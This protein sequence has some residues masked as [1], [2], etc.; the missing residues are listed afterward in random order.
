MKLA[1]FLDGD[2]EALPP[3]PKMTKAEFARRIGATPQLVIAYI[4]GEAW[5]GRD[6][7]VAI[8]RETEGLV[9]AN[10]FVE[11]ETAGAAQ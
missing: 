8:M 10:D 1:S 6:K 4:K 11:A 3:R 2:Q 7:M 5:P 9:T